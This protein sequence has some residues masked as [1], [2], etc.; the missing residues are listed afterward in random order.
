MPGRSVLDSSAA[1]AVALGA[2]ALALS[3]S[4]AWAFSASFAWC[5]GSPSFQL[6]DVPR[7]T[8]K[9]SFAM[10]DLN[11][12]SFRH[13]GGTVAYDGPSVPCGAFAAGFTGPSPPPGEVHTYEITVKALGADGRTLA[14]AKARRRY[15]Q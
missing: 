6:K 1:Y 2:A 12:P 8:A 4:G 13:G 5:A 7:G 10:T 3:P 15:P 9:V 14:T 11:V